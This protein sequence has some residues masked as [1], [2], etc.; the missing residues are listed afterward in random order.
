MD[1]DITSNNSDTRYIIKQVTSLNKLFEEYRLKFSIYSSVDNMIKNK[2]KIFQKNTKKK[3][4]LDL[5]V[6]IDDKL[7]NFNLDQYSIKS[8]KVLDELKR[9]KIL[10][11]SLEISCN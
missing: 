5:F 3:N 6:N 4:N 11:Y 1:I 7:V 9:S 2:D 8:Y 10:D